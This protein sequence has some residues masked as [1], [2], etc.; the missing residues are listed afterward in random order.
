MY[1]DMRVMKTWI[2]WVLLV[3]GVIAIALFA[4][5]MTSTLPAIW[6]IYINIALNFIVSCYLTIQK[7]K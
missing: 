4:Y 7:N 1:P 3:T 5:W 2:V 6:C